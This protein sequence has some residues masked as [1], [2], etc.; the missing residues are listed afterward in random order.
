MTDEALFI[1]NGDGYVAT[2]VGLGPWYPGA[3]HGGAPA[4]LI[5][6]TLAESLPDPALKLTR[7]T[8]ELVRPVMA[9]PMSVSITNS[10][11]APL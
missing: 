6:H 9:G 10:D 3:L 5:A 4:A 11:S 7:I 1:R 8:Y 2:E